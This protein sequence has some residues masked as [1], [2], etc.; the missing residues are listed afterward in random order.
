MIKK[1][2]CLLLG[3]SLF[4][5]GCSNATMTM[6]ESGQVAEYIA[7]SLLKYHKGE[8]V[9]VSNADKEEKTEEN[10][11]EPVVPALEEPAV[12]GLP[13]VQPVTD[14][15]DP[16]VDSG[17]ERKVQNAGELFGSSDFQISVRNKGLY[18]SYPKNSSSTYFS[19][20]ANAGKKILVLEVTAK[21]TGASNQ[22]FKT[23]GTGMEYALA[24]KESQKALVTILERDIHFM[25]SAVKPG[26]SVKSRMF[27]EVNRDFKEKD[28]KV[29]F[30]NEGKSVS[31]SVKS[32]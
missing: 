11:K 25:K 32:K 31:V 6:S 1:R 14:E 23:S 22:V 2:L 10:T 3:F 28:I 27:F 30:T 18:Q 26:K 13:V 7:Y 29:T 8:T 5:T 16:V 24:G 19:L 15:P 17:K 20:S 4:M 21:N 12:T 9:I